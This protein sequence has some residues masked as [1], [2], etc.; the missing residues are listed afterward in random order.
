MPANRMAMLAG[1]VAKLRI[2]VLE[3]AARPENANMREQLSEIV[4]V[5]EGVLDQLGKLHRPD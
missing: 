2:E 3:F 4:A 5:L 1:R